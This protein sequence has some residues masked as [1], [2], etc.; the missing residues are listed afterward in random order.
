MPNSARSHPARRPEA[1]PRPSTSDARGS[2]NTR[3]QVTRDRAPPAQPRVQCFNCKE[4]GHMAAK[5]PKG[6][7]PRLRAARVV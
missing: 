3:A 5:C 4:Y 2:T 6:Q 1:Q 7:A